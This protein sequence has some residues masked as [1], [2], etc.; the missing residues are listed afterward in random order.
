[1]NLFFV[2][3]PQSPEMDEIER[4][5][6]SHAI[7]FWHAKTH[8]G[9]RVTDTT[10]PTHN[11]ARGVCPDHVVV[12]VECHGVWLDE[13]ADGYSDP[14]MTIRESAGKSALQQVQE[15]LAEYAE[16]QEVAR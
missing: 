12:A 7:P 13:V 2:L 6:M 15:L 3:G 1:M 10:T 9:E 11:A 5:C 4:L 14:H 8:A 16:M